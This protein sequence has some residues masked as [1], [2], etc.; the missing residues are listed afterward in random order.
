MVKRRVFIF[1]SEESSQTANARNNFE[2]NNFCR[3]YEMSEIWRCAAFV[4]Q[5]SQ[6]RNDS[7]KQK[8]NTRNIVF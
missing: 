7:Q 6:P 3:V 2:L 8:K 4:A 1:S 5:R